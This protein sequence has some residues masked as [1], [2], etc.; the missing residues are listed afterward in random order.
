[1]LNKQAALSALMLMADDAD[2][3]RVLEVP[4][5]SNWGNAVKHILQV[6]SKGTIN[7]PTNWCASA[8]TNYLLVAG[9]TYDE[10][11]PEPYRVRQWS[12]WAK[13]KSIWTADPRLANR[14]DLF[15][16]RKPSFT[17]AVG[18]IG[19]IAENH[20]GKWLRTVEGNLHNGL[21]RYGE[22]GSAYTTWR[23]VRDGFEIVRLTKL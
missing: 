10:L 18:H 17:G 6:A 15:L 14:G 13:R 16:Y 5:G 1:M 3:R 20:M 7:F 12:D 2:K 22:Q 23:P 8:V 21:N 4:Y 19:F 9:A 11:P